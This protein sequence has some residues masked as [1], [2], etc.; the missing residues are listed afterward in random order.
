MIE[1]SYRFEPQRHEETLAALIEELEALDEWTRP[2]Y[3]RLLR[4]YPKN[5][6]GFYSKAEILAGFRHLNAERGWRRDERRFAAKIRMKPIR[7]LSGVAPVTV[8]TKPYPCP[9]RCIFCPSDVRMPKSYLSDE[10]G[11]QRAAEHRFDPYRQ[12]LSR[13]RALH[14][15]GHPVDKVELIVLGGTWSSYPEAY[16][17]WFVTRCFD[18]LNG[19][20]AWRRDGAIDWPDDP[21]VDY[22]TNTERIDGA[23]PVRGYNAAV[24]A[25]A[26]RQ[27]SEPASGDSDSDVDWERLAAAQERN[28]AAAARCVGLVLETRPDNLDAAEA[29]RLRR[30]GATK[31]Q[32]GLQSLDDRVL[33]MNRRGHDVAAARR[34][35]RLL[36]GMG[37]KIH[38]HWM[39]NLYGSTPEAD[40]EDFERLFADPAFRPDEL[41]I[42]PCSLI[43][44]AELMRHYESGAWR[45][46]EHDE[47]LAVLTACL[48]RTPEYCRVTR[49]VR[50][51]PGTDIVDGNKLTNFREIAERAID[52][53][54]AR[55]REIRSR[56][57]RARRID[58]AELTLQRIDY[59]T[60]AGREVFF[61]FVT[62]DDRLAAFLRLALPAAPAPVEE[63]G[64]SAVLREVHVYGRLVEIGGRKPGRSQHR[65]LG[66]RLIEAAADEARA[67]GFEN[68]AVI[69]SVGTRRYYR[70]LG[71]TDGPLY[72][73]RTLV[74][75][76]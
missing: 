48:V 43:E 30:L 14:T 3:E 65:G 13:L 11:A 20:E 41:K 49:V 10:P 34:A 52:E 32:L 18:A 51:I 1:S 4:R 9:G 29:L 35:F 60:S 42:Y 28:E 6:C 45:P 76:R 64:R 22:S 21:P 27:A 37:F 16:Q 67:R 44:S 23:R 50:D 2:A 31:V 24:T 71:F 57:V 55:R 8:L 61:Q 36:R 26:E 5:G 25:F 69:S 59:A 12:T 53:R 15:I 70:S 62:P 33:A 47:L 39:P 17:V 7:T 74:A 75:G 40:V 46:Y 38:A 58:P 73:H 68:L 66:R 54:G 19:F 63:L 72:Q 56:E